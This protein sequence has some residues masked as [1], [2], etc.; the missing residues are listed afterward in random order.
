MIVFET[1][2]FLF[3]TGSS[4]GLLFDFVSIFLVFV[5]FDYPKLP[6]QPLQGELYNVTP[7]TL[8]QLDI[9]EG[10]PENRYIRQEIALHQEDQ[11]AFIYLLPTDI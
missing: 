2:L 1:N 10:V 7:E 3:A 6:S 4:L 11:K 9:L 5:F 8:H